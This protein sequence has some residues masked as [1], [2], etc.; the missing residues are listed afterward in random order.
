M[1]VSIPLYLWVKDRRHTP[2]QPGNVVVDSFRQ[3]ARTFREIRHYRQI[4]WFLLA[5]LVYNDGLITVFA[6]GG[7]YAAGTFHFEIEEILIFGIVLNITA[8]LGAF[9]MG[10]LD[11]KLGGKRTL[12]I[13]LVGLAA[14]TL[15]A[16]L[17]PTRAWFWVAGITVG[18][19]SGPN[20][21]ASRSLMARFV[22]AEKENEFFGFF[23]FSGK[24]TAFLGPTLLGVFTQIS[25]SQ[26]VG[27]SVVLVLFALGLVLLSKVNEKEGMA[28]ALEPFPA[29]S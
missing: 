18:I 11:D 1:L 10:F 14:A 16:V 24:A 22:P 28:A 6:F 17:A 26:R 25:G 15:L 7:I 3:L 13:S 21:S 12:Q 5:R 9:A 8:G 23:A 4:L 2:V 29:Q 19:F 20:Q 27:I